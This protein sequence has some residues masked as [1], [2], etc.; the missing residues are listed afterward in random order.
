MRNGFVLLAALSVAVPAGAQTARPMLDYATAAKMRDTCVA[1]ARDH[2]TSVAIAIFDDQGRLV[3]YDVM[4]GVVNVAGEL[5]QWKAKGAGGY[6]VSTADMAKWGAVGVPGVATLAGGL[7]MYTADG[8]AL[9]AIGV[10]GGSQGTDVPC[11]QVAIAAAGLRE[12]AK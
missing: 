1:Y 7:P 3:T 4:D 12:S 2:Q 6:R 11:A 10:S 8:V 9:G 5:A